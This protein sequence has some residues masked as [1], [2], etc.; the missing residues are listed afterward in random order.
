MRGS[1]R[2]SPPRLKKTLMADVLTPEQ[3]R[4]CMSRN[5]TKNTSPERAVRRLAFSMGYRFRLHHCDL[6]GTPDLVFVS[7]RR[8]IFVHGCFWHG[9]RCKYG[10]HLPKTNTA[11]WAEKRLTNRRRDIRATR[12]LVSNGWRILRVWECQ[13]R[14]EKKFR[15]RIAAFMSG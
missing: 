2:R 6:P 4:L 1:T 7:L 12:Q 3:R 11:F 13:V 8:V 10:R 9:H 5:R 15:E 14:D